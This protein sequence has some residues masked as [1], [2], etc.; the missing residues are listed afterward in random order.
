MHPRLLAFAALC[1]GLGPGSACSSPPEPRATAGSL[2]A[3]APTAR[4]PDEPDE[5]AAL[6]ELEPASLDRARRLWA[7]QCALCHG[8]AGRGDGPGA[9]V[10]FPPPRDFGAGRFQL[11]STRNGFPTAEDLERV[12]RRGMPGSAMPPFAWM[13]DEDL[14]LLVR[15]V[16]QLAVEAMAGRLVAGGATEAEANAIA[17]RR[18]APGER[19]DPGEPAPHDAPTLARG[20]ALYAA[21]CAECHGLD[22]RGRREEPRWNERGDIEWARDFTA[23]VLKGGASHAE[24][25]WRIESGMPGSSMPATHFEDPADLAA[26]VAYVQ[27]L[28]PEDAGERLVRHRRTIVARAVQHAPST[29]DDGAWDAAPAVEVV[30]APNAWRDDAVFRATLAALHDGERLAVRVRWP[31]PSCNDHPFGEREL[32]DGAALMLSDE[33]QPPLYGMGSHE[34][35]VDIWHW[36]AF[37]TE[38]H[39]GELDLVLH[40]PHHLWGDVISGESVSDV[41]IY[42]PALPRDED[43][44]AGAVRAEGLESA[45]GFPAQALP[46]ETDAVWRDGQWTLT[47]SR[48]LHPLNEREIEIVPGQ[49]VQLALAIWNGATLDAGGRKSVSVWH[50]L[51]LR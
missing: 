15:Y 1:A 37:R 39:A 46:I 50:E 47:L 28:L 2:P 3:D 7:A 33:A 48:P 17:S 25:A 4:L 35:P 8:D 29:G 24:L 32:P 5:I 22:G 43:G 16:S 20:R 6:V 44:R 21:S 26:L 9:S 41:P 49:P 12:I 13:E 11:I 40:P 14:G 18:M 34:H 30:L 42:V 10:L 38:E 45:P 51:V 36:K 27:S 23:G 19:I 31:D